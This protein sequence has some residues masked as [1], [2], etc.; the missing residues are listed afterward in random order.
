MAKIKKVQTPKNKFLQKM[1][2]NL[3]KSQLVP[4]AVNPVKVPTVHDVGVAGTIKKK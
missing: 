4:K 2:S 3:V 1:M